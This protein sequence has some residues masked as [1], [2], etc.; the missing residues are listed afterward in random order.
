MIKPMEHEEEPNFITALSEEEAN[1][2][3]TNRYT[4][5]GYSDKQDCWR[6]K[7]RAGL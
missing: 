5:I 7:K 4:F 1:R 3:N 6:F 2:V